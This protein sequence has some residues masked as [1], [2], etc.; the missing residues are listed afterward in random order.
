MTAA[1][2]TGLLGVGWVVW[3]CI[4]LAL[5]TSNE[6]AICMIFAKWDGLEMRANQQVADEEQIADE[7]KEEV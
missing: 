5:I 1:L 6:Y 4:G 7:E 3:V 2:V